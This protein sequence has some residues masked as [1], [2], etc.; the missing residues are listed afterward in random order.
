VPKA[1]LLAS[2]IVILLA[3]ALLPGATIII[4]NALEKERQSLAAQS[5]RYVIAYKPF[6]VLCANKDRYGRPALV[7]MGVPRTLHAAGRL[8]LDSEGLL[9]LTDDG[10]LL[11]RVTHPDFNHPKSYLALVV[12][13]PDAAILQKLRE[14]VEIK[15]GIT[16]PADVEVLPNA[17]ALPPFPKP[18]AAP[19]K[20]T[21]L[22]IVLYEGKKRQIKRML[23]A[24]ALPIIRLVRVG[25]GPLTLPPDLEPGQWRNLTVAEKQALLNWV[26][27]RSG[28][29]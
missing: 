9:L 27:S 11:H 14:G 3:L 28:G 5:Y 17:P 7:D 2:Q 25:I 15:D 29:H 12:G 8:D 18:L 10:A 6:N 1:K 26:W 22:R 20:T 21:W 16:C 24:V 19:S 4:S 23:S 13:Q